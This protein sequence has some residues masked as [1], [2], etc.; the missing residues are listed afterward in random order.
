M[1]R[2][3]AW[4]RNSL[5]LVGALAVG[6]WLGS[7]HSAKAAGYDAGGN[8]VQF[9]LTGVDEASSLLVYEPGTRTV[10]V[11]RGATVG[12]S[13]LQCSYMYRLSRPGETIHR[14]SCAVGSLIQ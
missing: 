12:N 11:Y 10:Y 8:G 9:Q 1:E 4:V 5:A 14:E 6:I 13:A 3:V 2:T 7:A